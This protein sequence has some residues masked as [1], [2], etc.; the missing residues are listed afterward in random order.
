MYAHPRTTRPLTKR[1][2]EV[3]N[4]I[5]SAIVLNGYPPTVRELADALG[6]ASTNTVND[7]LECLEL[8]GFIRRDGSRERRGSVA[9]NIVL[10][11][12]P[13][14]R[15][16][17]PAPTCKSGPGIFL[18]VVQGDTE[19]FVPTPEMWREAVAC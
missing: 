10:L 11:R 2:S 17:P 6:V 13:L 3:L 5:A 9:R 4:K 1:Q 15:R 7:H 12:S 18:P 19:D 14:P 8:K 16:E